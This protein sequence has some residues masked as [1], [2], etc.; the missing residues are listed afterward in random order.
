MK[1]V[2]A[3]CRFVQRNF[4][5]SS[6]ASNLLSEMTVQQTGKVPNAMARRTRTL[7]LEDWLKLQDEQAAEAAEEEKK[8]KKPVKR[9]Q[10]DSGDE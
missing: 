10:E 8:K 3:F 2:A 1:G 4:P 7:P 9:K 5:E 6:N